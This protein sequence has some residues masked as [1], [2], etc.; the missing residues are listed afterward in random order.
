[1]D[2]T[3][4]STNSL[5]N[6]VQFQGRW[7]IEEHNKFIEGLKLFGKDWKKIEEYIGSRTCA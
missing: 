1:M 4:H 3:Y 7:T 2:H 6:G 5:L